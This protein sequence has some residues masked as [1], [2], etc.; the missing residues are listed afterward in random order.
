MKLHAEFTPNMQ[1][2]NNPN[3]AKWCHEN[4]CWAD[5][6]TG[7]VVCVELKNIVSGTYVCDHFMAKQ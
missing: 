3:K 2:D 4:S 5:L 6:Q 7:R 1:K